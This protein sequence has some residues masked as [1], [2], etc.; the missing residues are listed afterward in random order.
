METAASVSSG[1]P[2]PASTSHNPVIIRQSRTRTIKGRASL[3]L[4]ADQKKEGRQRDL[5]LCHQS[6]IAQAE[7]EV[8]ADDYVWQP[9][10]KASSPPATHR[11]RSGWIGVV[12]VWPCGIR[13][14]H[15]EIPARQLPFSGGNRRRRV[16]RMARCAPPA[17]DRRLAET[18]G[19]ACDDGAR[20]GGPKMA[21]YM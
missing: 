15:R 1:N 5:A 8:L 6:V 16:R 3:I 19:P 17:G 21:T 7:F 18:E 14:R 11:L 9:M 20:V 2:I 4:L 13:C 10:Q 12:R